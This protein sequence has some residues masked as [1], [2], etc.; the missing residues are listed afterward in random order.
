MREFI[1]IILTSPVT[2]VSLKEMEK[3]LFLPKKG[4]VD[5]FEENEVGEFKKSKVG[6]VNIKTMQD[7]K[8]K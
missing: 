5:E 2:L 6:E 8:T 1:L 7:N 3:K 4:E